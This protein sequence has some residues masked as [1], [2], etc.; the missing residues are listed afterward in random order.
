LFGRDFV[1]GFLDIRLQ[2]YQL[3]VDECLAFLFFRQG[4]GRALQNQ[5]IS[6]LIGY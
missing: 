3:L 6:Q 4:R 1:L 5:L 2:A